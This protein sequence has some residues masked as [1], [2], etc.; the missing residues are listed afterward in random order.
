MGEE[1]CEAVLVE[2]VYFAFEAVAAGHH[3]LQTWVV[4]E[5]EGPR[6]DQMVVLVEA[7]ADSW[8]EVGD[9][10]FGEGPEEVLQMAGRLMGVLQNLEEH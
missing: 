6:I 9:F 2:E 4:R 7:F 8:E 10:A 3:I 5:E 1:A